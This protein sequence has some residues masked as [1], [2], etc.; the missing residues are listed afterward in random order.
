MVYKDDKFADLNKLKNH[1]HRNH[2]GLQLKRMNIL[3][4]AIVATCI[5]TESAALDFSKPVSA[6]DYHAV[7]YQTRVF[8]KLL[9]V[10]RS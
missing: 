4:L 9:Q 6:V 5:L 7:N 10:T 8:Y 3:L 2:P 1:L